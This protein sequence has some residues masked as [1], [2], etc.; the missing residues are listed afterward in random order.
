MKRVMHTAIVSVIAAQ[1]L[2]IGQGNDVA[3]VLADVR[4]ALGGE[5]KLAAVR[6]LSAEGT[7]TRSLPDG[8]SR[9]SRFEMAFELPDKFVKK[10]AIGMI[11]GAAIARTS[12]FNGDVAIDVTDMP[13]QF[14]GGHSIMVRPGGGTTGGAAATPEQQQQ[15]RSAA[16]QSSR[17][18]FARLVLGMLGTSMQAYP[19]EFTYAGLA[20]SPDGKAD[21]LEVRHTDGFT[22]KIFIDAASR[23][24]LMLSWMDKEPLAMSPVTM[25]R[26][27]VQG[28][29]GGG[30]QVVRGGSAGSMSKEDIDRMMREQQERIKEAE[31]RRRIVEYRMFYADY[32]AVDG[33]KLPTRIQRMIAG[34][35]VDELELGR[36]RVNPR[37]DAKTFAPASES[38]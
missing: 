20:E 24:P 28:S 33:V 21:V 9:G 13:P 19:L 31:A 7:N 2:V 4:R 16:L 14:A 8:T 10:E 29:G 6:T 11:N 35:P 15:M 23:L 34:Q 22:A 25:T 37:L 26:E 18:E 36:I 27:G 1:V 30:M 32:K 5:E 38:R 17:R 3:R 12:G